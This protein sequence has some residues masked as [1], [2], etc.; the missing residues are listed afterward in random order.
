MKLPWIRDSRLVA[1]ALFGNDMEHHRFVDGFQM[2]ECF[3]QQ[4]DIMTVDRP[5]ITHAEF[6]EKDV[7]EQQILRALLDLVGKIAHRLA[8]DFLHKIG[9]LVAHRRIG[10][11]GLQGVEVLGDG[12]DVFIDRPLVVIENHDEFS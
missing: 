1:A 3:H 7:G 11:V 10:R 8:G 2:L 5:V 6:L 4:A 9:G 12:A